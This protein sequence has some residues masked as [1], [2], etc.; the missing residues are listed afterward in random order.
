MKK[1]FQKFFGILV[2]A[3][4]LL[5]APFAAM[6]EDDHLLRVTGSAS[7]LLDADLA[8]LQVAVT[9]SDAEIT[10]AQQKNAERMNAVIAALQNAGIS[11]KD[12]STSGFNIYSGVDYSLPESERAVQYHVSNTLHITVRDLTQI[13]ELIDLAILSGAT[14]MYGLSFSAS[15]TG[16]A[17]EQALSE[18]VRDA[19]AKA[20]ILC[21]AAGVQLDGILLID[22]SDAGIG[23]YTSYFTN[24]RA[25][26]AEEAAD[27]AAVVTGNITVS[28]QV[29][30]TYRIK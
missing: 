21:E 10:L 7:V 29:T 30:I 5:T 25:L 14:E 20:Q 8:D 4:L 22:A 23:S 13:G 3:A 12:M 9:T 16:K 28:A 27:G 11:E 19:A 17:Y 1:Q 26:K 6:A 24:A 15:E 2:C 18:A